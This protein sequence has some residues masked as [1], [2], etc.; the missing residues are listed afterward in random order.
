MP[1]QLAIQ[2][3]NFVIEMLW[4]LIIQII[5]GLHLKA[6]VL[7][8]LTVQIGLCSIPQTQGFLPC[9]PPRLQSMRVMQYGLALIVGLQNIMEAAGL[10]ITK[11]IQ[12][13]YPIVLRLL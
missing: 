6:L 12:E 1:C 10:F 3:H 11:S 13:L 8:N 2:A 4:Q 7:E 9:T 5:N